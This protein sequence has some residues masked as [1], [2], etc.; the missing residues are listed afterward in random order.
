LHGQI[1][2]YLT[3]HQFSV[4]FLFFPPY[5]PPFLNRQDKPGDF[6]GFSAAGLESGTKGTPFFIQQRVENMLH[7]LFF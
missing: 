6:P 4:G 7:C 3:E 2:P 5:K 1:L